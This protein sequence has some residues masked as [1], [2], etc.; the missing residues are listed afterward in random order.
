MES[1]LPTSINS[2]CYPLF[3]TIPFLLYSF[4]SLKLV[5]LRKRLSYLISKGNFP[6][7]EKSNEATTERPEVWS[8]STARAAIT[9]FAKTRKAI[10]II[11][12][13]VLIYS[14]NPPRADNCCWSICICNYVTLSEQVM[15]TRQVRDCG[16]RC[17]PLPMQPVE[18]LLREPAPPAPRAL[19]IRCTLHRN[20]YYQP[21]ILSKWNP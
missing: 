8:G 14:V 17:P 13:I 16:R 9:V 11:W 15:K 18:L 12:R 1:T 7:I 6:C 19:T 3:L 10:N 20:I 4:T 21:I 5:F 2:H